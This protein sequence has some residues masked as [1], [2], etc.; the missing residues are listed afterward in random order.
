MHCS[1][2]RKSEHEV[3]VTLVSQ[4]ARPAAV[5][6]LHAVWMQSLRQPVC[7]L[8]VWLTNEDMQAKMPVGSVSKSTLNGVRQA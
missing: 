7:W 5:H 3:F 4:S 2:F 6:P 8:Q 1:L